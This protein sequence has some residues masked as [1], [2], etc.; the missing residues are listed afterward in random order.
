MGD[1]LDLLLGHPMVS[2]DRVAA[3]GV[4]Q[5]GEYPLLLNNARH[6]LAANI[7]VYGGA[8]QRAWELSETRQVPYEAIIERIT[9]P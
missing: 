2:P 5:S 6:D 7:V 4:C 3:M 1:S 9:A 8:Q